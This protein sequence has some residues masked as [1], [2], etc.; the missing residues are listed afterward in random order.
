MNERVEKIRQLLGELE[1]EMEDAAEFVG[2]RDFSALELPL[3]IQEIVDDLQP[4]LTPYDAAFYWY[5]FRHSIS[6]NGNPHL[7]VSTRNLQRAVVKSSY[8]YA[9]ENTISLDKVRET[10]RALE[11]VGAI[12]KEGEPTRD[13]TPYRILIPDEIEACRKFRAERSAA[14]SKTEIAAA[15]ID[16]YNVRE[17]RIRVYE[18][19]AY[20]CRYCENS[21]LDSPP[22]WIMS[23][24]SLKGATT[25]LRI[26][27]LH[28][29]LAILV[30]TSGRLVTFLRNNEER[31]T[32]AAGSRMS[33]QKPY[34]PSTEKA[35]RA[36]PGMAF[37]GYPDVM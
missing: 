30:S 23:R 29:L 5:L 33:L 7:R 20:R 36:F 22:R 2:D 13:G 3:V 16:H 31:R 35:S 12:R 18:R 26:L 6:E 37:P 17:N 27:S 11:N 10:L 32:N 4:L 9:A 34:L 28:A 1:N 8:S 21:S 24:P 14:E 25:A 19:D 15:D